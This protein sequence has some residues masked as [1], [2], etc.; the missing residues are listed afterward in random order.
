MDSGTIAALPEVPL[1]IGV[2]QWCV[3][4]TVLDANV[5]FLIFSDQV[6]VQR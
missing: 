5:K 6:A 1:R 2:V 3:L 4:A